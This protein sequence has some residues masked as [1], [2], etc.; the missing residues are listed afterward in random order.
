MEILV[1]VAII[2]MIISFII[3]LSGDSRA[4]KR[5]ARREQDIKQLQNALGLYESNNQ[6]YPV[7]PRGVID[8]ST[9]CLSKE[10]IVATFM[11]GVPSDPLGGSDGICGGTDSFVYCY[12][13][14]GVVY[15]IEYALETDTV[16]GKSSGWQVVEVQS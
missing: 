15:T 3:A 12:T 5:D 1:V 16:S 8:G 13:S 7:C 4:Q 10:L 14:D 9:D 6:L 11:V 2:A